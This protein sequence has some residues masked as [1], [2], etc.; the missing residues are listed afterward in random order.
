MLGL[1]CLDIARFERTNIGMAALIIRGWRAVQIQA[2]YA[3]YRIADDEPQDASASSMRPL[4]VRAQRPH[5][6]LQ[7]RQP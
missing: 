3:A 4:I 1:V 2:L 5:S 6:T 7:P